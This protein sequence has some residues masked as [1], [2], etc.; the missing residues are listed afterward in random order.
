MHVVATF[1]SP[2]WRVAYVNRTT[3]EQR[4]QPSERAQL[5]AQQQE[6][7]EQYFEMELLVTTYNRPENDLQKNARSIWKLALLDDRGNRVSPIEVKRDR[8][9]P[10]VIRSYF[11]QLDH[12][13]IAYVVRFP[14]T[15]SILR[16]DAA[17]FSLRIS[18]ARG[19]VELVWRNQRSL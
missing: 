11:P 14:K 15:I 18:G 13:A 4:L 5:L 3:K 7:A 2:A 19:A 12:F 6:Q 16:P 9:P 1:K 17:Q 10:A 8:R